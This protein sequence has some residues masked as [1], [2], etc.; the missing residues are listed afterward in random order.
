MSINELLSSVDSEITL[1]K[2]VRSLLTGD[3]HI[4]SSTPRKK[5]FMSAAARKRIGDAQRKRWAAQ[6]KAAKAA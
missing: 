5:R 1:L 3:G 2:Q 4:A 6:R